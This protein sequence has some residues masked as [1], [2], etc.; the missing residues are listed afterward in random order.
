MGPC[1]TLAE[2]VKLGGRIFRVPTGPCGTL[3]HQPCY[4]G[5]FYVRSTK[6]STYGMT[7]LLD[8]GE[9][10]PVICAKSERIEGVCVLKWIANPDAMFL[11]LP[12]FYYGKRS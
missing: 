1:T 9:V 10:S 8:P 4:L 12:T 3:R 5:S 11:A 6:Q 7:S 2:H